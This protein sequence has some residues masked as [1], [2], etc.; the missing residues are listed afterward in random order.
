MVLAENSLLW[1]GPK[2]LASSFWPTEGSEMKSLLS[3]SKGRGSRNRWQR[4]REVKRVLVKCLVC[5]RQRFGAGSPKMAPLPTERGLFSL[6]FTHFGIDFA[7]PLYVQEN[8]SPHKSYL[9]IFTCASSR[10]AHLELTSDLSTNAFL[11]AF[12]HMI[13]RR[14]LCSIIWSDK[15]NTFKCADRQIR[16]L[17]KTQSTDSDQ[18]NLQQRRKGG[19]DVPAR[20]RSG[21]FI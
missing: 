8:P 13:S 9:C 5:Q 20:T 2:W 16:K 10:I 14:G 19:E 7:G 21:R 17:Y 4:I 1:N 15:A 12:N 6:T 18:P 11:Q 3:L